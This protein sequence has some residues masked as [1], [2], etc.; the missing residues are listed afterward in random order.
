MG[1]ENSP[2]PPENSELLL[3]HFDTIVKILK[4]RVHETL[5]NQYMAHAEVYGM[6]KTDG[7]NEFKMQGKTFKELEDEIASLVIIRPTEAKTEPS[8]LYI[9][10]FI[11]KYGLPIDVIDEIL[12]K[13][14]K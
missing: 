2:Q 6:Q 1:P 14:F 9:M 11:T 3:R 12:T 7:S 10:D 13:F 5:I 4:S 8:Q